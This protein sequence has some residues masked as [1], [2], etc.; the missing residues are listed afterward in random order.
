VHGKCL[1]HHRLL[2]KFH[3]CL[4]SIN[5][6]VFYFCI[7]NLFGKSLQRDAACCHL[8]LGEVRPDTPV[9]PII[10]N[11]ARKGIHRLVPT[12][13]ARY[14]D[15]VQVGCRRSKPHNVTRNLNAALDL[16]LPSPSA[17]LKKHSPYAPNS[18][19][20]AILKLQRKIFRCERPHSS[21]RQ[22][23]RFHFR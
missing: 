14:A 12:P 15:H 1:G 2:L 3:N 20:L 21:E 5:S 13:R 22:Y 19:N 6:S 23:D 16:Q 17:V 10:A 11:A 18:R 9:P 7:P 8:R 4:T